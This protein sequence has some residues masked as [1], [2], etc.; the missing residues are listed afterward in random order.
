MVGQKPIHSF[1]KHI[2]IYGWAKTYS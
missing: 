1:K 2:A